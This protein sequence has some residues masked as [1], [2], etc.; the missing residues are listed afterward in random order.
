MCAQY[1]PCIWARIERWSLFCNAFV[2]AKLPQWNAR[3]IFTTKTIKFSVKWDVTSL[4]SFRMNLRLQFSGHFCPKCRS[5]QVPQKGKLII[6][7]KRCH[8][9]EDIWCSTFIGSLVEEL[10]EWST[11]GVLDL[12]V[13]SAGKERKI[14]HVP[15]HSYIRITDRL[16]HCPVCWISCECCR[17][18]KM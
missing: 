9:L 15:I 7:T 4:S 18:I 14:M 1:A 10:D 3:R 13:T 6:Q 16:T 8:T 12:L 17:Y 2:C 11:C 5:Q